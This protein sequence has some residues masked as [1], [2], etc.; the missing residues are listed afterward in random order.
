MI[1]LLLP[2]ILLC[3]VVS[4]QKYNFRVF[5]VDDGLADPYVYKIVQ[6]SKGFLYA[7]TGDG[8]S[9]FGGNK[10]RNMF[11]A[12]GLAENFINT[13]FI[14]HRGTLWM[15][16]YQQ[17]ISVLHRLTFLNLGLEEL[18]GVRITKFL[19]DTLGNL[20][21]ATYGKGIF[22]LG[23]RAMPYRIEGTADMVNDI[24]FTSDGKL[25]AVTPESFE[26]YRLNP[27]FTRAEISFQLDSLASKDFQKI[28]P[29]KK[30]QF[31]LCV[32]EYGLVQVK[33]MQ[34]ECRVLPFRNELFRGSACDFRDGVMDPEGNIWL[35]TFGEGLK[36]IIPADDKFDAATLFLIDHSNGLPTDH[37]QSLFFDREGNL[38]IGT[39]G[40]GLVQMINERFTQFTGFSSSSDP[41]IYSAAADAI[42]QL[43]IGTREG[44]VYFIPGSRAQIPGSL[45]GITKEK[46]T[47][48]HPDREGQIWAGSENG[49]IYRVDP[50]KKSVKKHRLSGK[51]RYIHTIDE[52]DGNIYFATSSGLCILDPK[53]DA[54]Q[55]L[56]TNEGLLHNNVIRTLKTGDGRLWI[57]SHETPPYF[58]YNGKAT[59]FNEVSG[60]RIFDLND[61]AEGKDGNVWIATGGDGL[62]RYDGKTF[63]RY[64]VENGLASNFCYSVTAD[65]QGN[66]WVTH[67]NG[68]SRM[69][70][71]ESWFEAIGKSKGFLSPENNLNAVYADPTGTVFFGTENGIIRYDP[72]KEKKNPV[73]NVT[74][75]LGI[76][77]NGKFLGQVYDTTISYGE[78]SLRI[79]YI[80]VCLT[81]P[82]QVRYRY[83]LEGFDP[84]W[85]ETDNAQRFV[86]YPKLADG[87]YFFRLLSRN[88]S[89]EWNK[90]PVGFSIRVGL[91]IWKR[92][93]FFVFC[94]AFLLTMSILYTRVRTRRLVRQRQVLKQQVQEQTLVI[95]R[96]KEEVERINAIV[97]EK[98]RDITSSIKYAVKIQEATLPPAE[99]MEKAING[100]I[101]YRPRDIVS[102]DFFWYHI[103]DDE[104][105]VIVAADCTGHGVPGAFVSLVGK[106]LLDKIIIEKKV[107][108]PSRILHML[109]E[110]VKQTLHQQG[111]DL[112]SQDGMELALL[113][114]SPDRKKVLFSG[115]NRPLLVVRKGELSEYSGSS[116]GIG[117]TY[118]KLQ[119]EFR[120][121]E[122]ELVTGDMLFVFSDGYA[123]QFG[124]EK[125]RKFSTRSLKNMLTAAAES[126]LNEQKSIISGTFDRWKGEGKQIDDVL[127][128]GVRI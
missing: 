116:F 62:F 94:L 89:G 107:T 65:I 96:E 79:D 35:A 64:S 115:A 100:I 87:H 82:S 17:G 111:E 102:G 43:W 46:I 104:R 18:K 128:I 68:I 10:F 90:I 70:Y 101:F 120:Q 19:Q 77:L 80:G 49:A 24:A 91:P 22:C 38:W 109:D 52:F 51:A 12:D 124:G 113:I 44:L 47:A 23:P 122:V 75:I 9:V 126:K 54:E 105:I 2:C 97:E 33:Y 59:V 29:G 34:G 15:G 73:E 83:K 92:W 103:L 117:G 76:T 50:S 119:K 32:K 31:F 60:L 74:T 69:M 56:G 37:L 72:R 118:G 26:V 84:E 3:G 61:L 5:G 63:K 66:I 127:L 110:G 57:A 6:D 20:F 125:G 86:S 13:Q 71:G 114:L 41:G 58:L 112:T 21:I 85:T 45:P 8:L 99:I 55:W 48:L 123:D 27:E 93:Y 4:A 14:D 25:L 1:R 108:E 98:N 16:H 36:K 106:M 39:Y 78:H 28:I 67:K 42:G 95:R 11:V 40:K 81:D 121:E 88:N 30:N 53:T 7:G